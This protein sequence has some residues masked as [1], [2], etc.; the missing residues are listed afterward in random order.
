M[1]ID[2]KQLVQPA[3][4]AVLV[5]ECQRGIVGG[6]A[7]L[8]ALGEAVQRHGTIGQIARARIKWQLK[9]Y[10]QAARKFQGEDCTLCRT[11]SWHVQKKNMK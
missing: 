1:P 3:T 8:G 11:P 2:L 7:A 9:A 4:T 6:G 10:A 5:M